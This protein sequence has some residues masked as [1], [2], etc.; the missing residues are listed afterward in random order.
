MASE[1]TAV[2][3]SARRIVKIKVLKDRELY[4]TV[5]ELC[6]KNPP[7]FAFVFWMLNIYQYFTCS[8]YPSYVSIKA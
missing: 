5:V 8:F 4:R 2:V 6:Q 1:N 7:E 3:Q